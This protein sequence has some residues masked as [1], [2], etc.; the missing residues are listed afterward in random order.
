VATKAQTNQTGSLAVE[1]REPLSPSPDG[2]EVGREKPAIEAGNGPPR[3]RLQYEPTQDTSPPVGGQKHAVFSWEKGVSDHRR[4]RSGS[5]RKS[6]TCRWGGRAQDD[7]SASA[8][9]TA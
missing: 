5:C 1:F 4:A 2:A 9:S 6:G 8:E 3:A 7:V